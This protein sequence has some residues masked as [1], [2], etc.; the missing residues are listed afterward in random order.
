M[1][2]ATLGDIHGNLPALE[3]V[4][5]DMRREGVEEVWLVGDQ[6]A[7]LPWHNEVLDIVAAEGWQGIY[8]NHELVIG[9]LYTKESP[10]YFADRER[11]IALYWTQETMRPEHLA[12]I[13]TLPS[14]RV[15]RHDGLPPIHLTHG[16]PGNSFRGIFPET[17]DAYIANSFRDV[18]ESLIVTAHTHR[19]LERH[20]ETQTI[21]NGGAVGLPY[22]GDPRAQYLI[23]EAD[24]AGWQHIFRRVEYDHARIPAGFAESGMSAAMGAYGEMHLLTAMSAQPWSSDFAWWLGRHPLDAFPTMAA[25]VETYRSQF[26]PG[27]WAFSETA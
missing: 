25:A 11:F 6:I 13:R 5:Q 23:L 17:C 18:P 10:P 24:R 14:D 22:N 19:Q 27:H 7:R 16:I 4:M 12:S 9:Q 15:I 8:G 2:I 1:R 26:G 3:A 21:L 20:T